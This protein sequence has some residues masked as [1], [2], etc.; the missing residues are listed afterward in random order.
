ML[1]VYP[2]I[3]DGKKKAGNMT[4]DHLF[5]QRVKLLAVMVKAAAKGFPMGEHRRLSMEENMDIICQSLMF[6]SRTEDMAFLKVA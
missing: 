6:N 5:Y 2:K 1:M 4:Y 3:K